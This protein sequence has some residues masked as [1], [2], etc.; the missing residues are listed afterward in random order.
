MLRTISLTERAAGHMRG[1]LTGQ[2]R[3][4]G[5]RLRVKTTGCSGY[6]YVVE[7]AD[8]I[9]ATDEVFESHGIKLVVDRTSLPFLV[10]TQVDY[11]REGLNFAFRF[12][13]PNVKASCG[14]GESF[15]V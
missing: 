15:S 5:V 7:V 11:I 12:Q 10:G 6:A 2:A 4:A 14:C 13:N 1:Y 3:A 9:E 8:A